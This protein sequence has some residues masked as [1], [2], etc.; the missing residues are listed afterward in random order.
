M[1]H[2][3]TITARTRP[4]FH[5][6][7]GF[8]GSWKRCWLAVFMATAAASVCSA[9]PICEKQ[10]LFPKEGATVC[11]I[12]SLV[13]TK[14]GVVLATGDRRIGSNHD[15]GHD[16]EIV[17]RRSVDGGCTWLPIQVLASEP[18]VNFHSGPSLVDDRTGRLFKF[19]K[20]RPASFRSSG[21]FHNA[22]LAD[23]DRWRRW[24]YGSYVIHSD[25]A[26]ATW[27]APRR[28]T[29]E[30]PDSMGITDVGNSVHGIQ[31]P[32]GRLVIQAYCEASKEWKSE[33]ENP[34]RS[35][36]L[37]SSDGGETW[38][39]AADWTAGY[40]A[41]EYCIAALPSG[42]IYINQ[43]S[44]GPHRKVASLTGPDAGVA[45][46]MHSDPNLPE[47]VCHAGLHAMPGATP[48]G[49]RLLFA[50]PAV[51]S[52][53]G[54]YREETRRM[55]TV[56][57]S[58]DGGRTWPHARLLDEGRSGYADLG[59]LPDGTILCLYENG[60]EHYDDQIS[61]ARFNREWL[62]TATAGEGSGTR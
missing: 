59:S 46:D 32:D 36:L 54:G 57:M 14:N 7:D 60:R 34:S 38:N 12:P 33:H 53:F 29:I 5:H 37:V 52:R 23:A 21:E 35:F 30:H 1:S 45:V 31:M 22:I 44:L 18:G 6:E 11:R 47:P 26:G 19:I 41:M 24:G 50:N 49:G 58:E 25:D 61:V 9:E 16:T 4:R 27:S 8:T 56:R 13:V 15:W 39:R 20:K 40:A 48:D 3:E 10:V 42:Q 2:T 51:E 62:A 55:L 43:R 17:L 28:L